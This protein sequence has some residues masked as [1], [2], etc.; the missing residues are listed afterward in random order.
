MGLIS[1]TNEDIFKTGKDS[2]NKKYKQKDSKFKIY[3]T[4]KKVRIKPGVYKSRRNIK[5]KKK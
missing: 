3:E 1:N 5:F 4:G 2:I